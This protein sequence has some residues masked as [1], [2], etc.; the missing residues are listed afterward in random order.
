MNKS[1]ENLL[2]LKKRDGLT[3]SL[4]EK[5]ETLFLTDRISKEEYLDLIVPQI[6]ENPKG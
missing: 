5:I 4:K 3:E 1:Y 6:A 2:K